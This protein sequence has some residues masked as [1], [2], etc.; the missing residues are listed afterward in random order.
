[1]LSQI[2]ENYLKCIYKIIEKKAEGASTNE[3]AEGLKTKAAT[4]TDMLKKLA[5]LNLINYQKYQAVTLTLKGKKLALNIIRNHRLWEVFLVDKLH[6]KWNEV[7]DVAEQMEH[8]KSEELIDRLEKFLGMPNLDPHGDPIPSKTGKITPNISKPLSEI[9]IGKAVEINGV[10][11]HQD[12]FLQHLNELGLT[13][14]KQV[15]VK[16]IV[17][18]D[19]SMLLEMEHDKHQFVSQ[20]VAQHILV[21]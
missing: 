3:I 16:K 19:G 14:G 1:M 8:I 6:F 9:E 15:K 20:I 10:N 4:V 7:H 21:K 18:F 2:Q 5:L 13:I 12:D 11:K 17:A